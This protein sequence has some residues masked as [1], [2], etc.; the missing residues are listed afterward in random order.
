MKERTMNNI[1]TNPDT[2]TDH[3][4]ELHIAI[5]GEGADRSIY[6]E[7]DFGGHRNGVAVHAIQVRYM[8]ELLGL[9]EKPDAGVNN[10]IDGVKG[11]KDV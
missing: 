8:A 11:V 7:Q 2:M 9:L 10:F 3:I 1:N 4:P 5:S 6:L